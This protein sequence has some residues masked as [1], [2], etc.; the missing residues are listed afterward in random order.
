MVSNGK[1]V[2]ELKLFGKKRLR[3]YRGAIL[4]FAWKN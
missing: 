2:D 1:I 3:A 4:L